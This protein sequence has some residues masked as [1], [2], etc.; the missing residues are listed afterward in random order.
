VKLGTLSSDAH[1]QESAVVDGGL[2]PSVVQF[3]RTPYYAAIEAVGRMEG[4]RG[5]LGPVM[6]KV[7]HTWQSALLKSTLV[8]CS[9]PLG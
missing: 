9:S 1:V 5:R 8:A 3:V 4:A 2:E 7:A 6:P